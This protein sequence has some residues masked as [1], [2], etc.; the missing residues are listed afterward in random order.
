MQ[1]NF[2]KEKMQKI[3]NF[4]IHF[5]K[6]QYN[7]QRNK[8]IFTA[9][10]FALNLQTIKGNCSVINH[11]YQSKYKS[12]YKESNQEV[13][14]TGFGD[15]IR[16]SY[17]ILEFCGK[18]NFTPNIIFNNCISKFLE[19]KPINLNKMKIELRNISFFPHT[20]WAK[21]HRGENDYILDPIP[22][23]RRDFIA[24]F[25]DYLM[26]CT[27]YN[28]NVN[29]YCIPYPF[30]QVS[31]SSKLFMQNVLKPNQE[32]LSL[33]N[34]ALNNLSLLKKVYKV[35]HIR[36]GDAYLNKTKTAVDTEYINDL[37]KKMDII[38]PHRKYLLIS[39]NN[40]IKQCVLQKYP[41][42]CSFFKEITHMGEGVVLEEEKVKN[43]MLDFYL[44][45]FANEIFAYSVYEHGSGFSYWCAKTYSIPYSCKYIKV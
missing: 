12:K 10:K 4:L 14:S 25:I 23:N 19:N 16:G 39:D 27:I 1:R 45:S 22:S 41:N 18:H 28:G 13:N 24:D 6:I 33:V 43:T 31:H 37:F 42:V 34:S 32:M 8:E 7:I 2:N 9:E 15:F 44:M 5:K 29:T 38:H 11:V 20:N 40:L 21:L 3:Q 30:D 35:I 17:F 26:T 36:S